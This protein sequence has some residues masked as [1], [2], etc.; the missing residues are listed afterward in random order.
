MNSIFRIEEMDDF[1][2]ELIVYFIAPYLTMEMT[3]QAEIRYVHLI[4]H[5][6]RKV[7]DFHDLKLF[8]IQIFPT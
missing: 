1:F 4:R 2:W 3:L 6:E 8:L 5:L 7:Y